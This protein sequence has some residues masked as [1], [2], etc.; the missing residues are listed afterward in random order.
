M[1]S[2]DANILIQQQNELDNYKIYKLLSRLTRDKHNEKILNEIAED[3][4]KH[5]KI[6]ESITKKKL[7]PNK[8]KIKFYTSLARSLGI[9]FTM[10][11]L[12]KNELITQNFYDNAEKLYPKTKGI[13]YDEKRHENILVAIL[14]DEKLSY[15]SSVV[16]GLNDALVELSG[17]L[18]GLSFAFSNTSIVGTTG[19]IMGIAASLSMAASEYLSS[20]EEE[21]NKS[22]HP[23]KSG[24]YTG[25]SYVITVML[26]VAPY[27]IFENIINSVV[28][29]LIT[30]I[31]IIFSYT[32]YISI[33]KSL[34]FKR[35]FFTMAIISLGVAGISFGL[36]IAVK[37]FLGIN[38]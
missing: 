34:N 3:E 13:S 2:V 37:H 36:G 21:H 24:T 38:V 22:K 28:T 30:S 18:V 7:K 15:A 32:W 31:L 27:F 23:L 20:S 12:E 25:I 4:L 6:W 29:M 9:V 5:Y 26:L 19:I 11:L 35:K 33:A 1:N 8:L 14:N 16:L 17:T 10:R